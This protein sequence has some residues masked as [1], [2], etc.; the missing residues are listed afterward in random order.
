MFGSPGGLFGARH[1]QCWR[2]NKRPA[3]GSPTAPRSICVTSAT[4]VSAT[5]SRA[6]AV[7]LGGWPVS[8]LPGVVGSLVCADAAGQGT[9]V[10]DGE[11]SLLAGVGSGD[12]IPLS[13]CGLS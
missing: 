4:E 8:W 12:P 11:F 1:C 9:E 5:G 10:A 3:P 2:A 6:R 7:L 13:G